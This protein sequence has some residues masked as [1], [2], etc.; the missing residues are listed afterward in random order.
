[1][2][3]KN[4]PNHVAIILDG[5]GRWAK[6]RGQSR[7]FGHYMG[8]RNLFSVAKHAKEMGIQKLSVYAFST[9]NWKRPQEEVD[10]LMTKPIE[11][12][13]KNKDKF[14]NIDY[15]ITFSGRRDR[16]SKELLEVMTEMENLTK[17]YQGFVLNVCVDYGSYD[18]II[19]AVN[20]LD[21]PITRE[22]FESEL[23]VKE[24]VDLLIRTSGEMRISNFL[25][26]QIAYAEFYFTKVHWPAFN[27]K[28]LEK[29]VKSY[30]KRQRRFG[31]L[32]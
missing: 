10:Y 17:D 12:Y 14:N 9:E 3:N 26:W 25:L 18:E 23:M 1:M 27:K 2:N 29:A 22:T 24:P 31:G 7:S 5:N 13:Y 20:K 11:L 30:Q 16:F 15:K 4:V 6:K 19:T 8:G 32:I 28:Q 21:K